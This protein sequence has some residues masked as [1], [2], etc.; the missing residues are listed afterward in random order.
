LFQL[1][2]ELR[3]QEGQRT[4]SQVVETMINLANQTTA[5]DLARAMV[6]VMSDQDKTNF[7]RKAWREGVGYQIAFSDNDKIS[8]DEVL[9]AIESM[10]KGE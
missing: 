10:L 8:V 5:T 9:N 7:T 6:S 1:F 2:S 4:L 3:D